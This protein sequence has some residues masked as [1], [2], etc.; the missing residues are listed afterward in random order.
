MAKASKANS[1]AM[2]VSLQEFSE[3]F[4]KIKTGSPNEELDLSGFDYKNL[5]GEKFKEYIRMVGDRSYLEK[6]DEGNYVPVNGSLLQEEKY[7]FVLLPARPI[8]VARFPGMENT[9]FDYIG[10]KAKDT[11]PI[12]T[13]RIPVKTA[14][15]HNAQIVNQHS[16]AGHGKYYFLKQS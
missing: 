13:T 5:T 9:P 1:G 16:R 8:M 4:E 12:H 2:N 6:N 15:E 14:L 11:E 10:L 7:D 3:N